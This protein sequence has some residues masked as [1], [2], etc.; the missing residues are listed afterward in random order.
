[1]L[2]LL[3]NT[4]WK[5]FKLNNLV[6]LSGGKVSVPPYKG[7]GFNSVFWRIFETLLSGFSER[8]LS[9]RTTSETEPVPQIELVLQQNL[10][11]NRTCS[12]VP[13]RTCSP[14]LDRT[15]SPVPNRTCS[16]VSGRTGTKTKRKKRLFWNIWG[17]PKRKKNQKNSETSWTFWTF[18][19]FR[20]SE[21]LTKLNFFQL[22]NFS[23]ILKS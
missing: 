1:M 21:I 14:V 16:P 3:I 11:S 22:F 18:Q 19:L 12:P 23:E 7:S 20:N 9:F 10:F 5:Q 15:C 6:E 13:N 8:V 2:N 17:P 4:S